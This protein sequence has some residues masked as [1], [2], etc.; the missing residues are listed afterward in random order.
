MIVNQLFYFPIESLKWISKL[1]FMRIAGKISL[2]YLMIEG[3][4]TTGNVCDKT[5]LLKLMRVVIS[6][7]LHGHTQ[8]NQVL[9]SKE[10]ELY[11]VLFLILCSYFIN[12]LDTIF[13]YTWRFEEC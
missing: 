10:F 5:D 7:K 4:Y 8:L 1:K 11:A 9:P 2:G 6:P 3:H 13:Q 12:K